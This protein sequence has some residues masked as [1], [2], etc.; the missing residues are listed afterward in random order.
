MSRKSKSRTRRNNS[1]SKRGK[2]KK[3]RKTQRRTRRNRQRGGYFD[4][5]RRGLSMKF[6]NIRGSLKKKYGVKSND[7][8]ELNKLMKDK[9]AS[10]T[11][12]PMK[13]NIDRRNKEAA[14]KA[15]TQSPELYA[16]LDKVNKEIAR[17]S[18][19][20]DELVIPSIKVPG[21][22]ANEE[23]IYPGLAGGR[24]GINDINRVN[25][26]RRLEFYK[27]DLENEI[28]STEKIMGGSLEYHQESI[29]V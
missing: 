10:F 26:L 12:G 6:N 1:K 7:N 3:V 4:D 21:Q 20:S 28:N 16:E 8:K 11:D 13:E 18:G 23:T 2:Y 17:I 22:L 29:S 15:R 19:I 27:M 5:L 14:V 24:R 9:Q 25:Y